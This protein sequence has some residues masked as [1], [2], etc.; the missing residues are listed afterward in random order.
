MERG[1]S[2]ASP[3]TERAS[4]EQGL[5]RMRALLSCVLLT[6]VL[7][8][9]SYSWVRYERDRAERPTVAIV[10]LENDSAE[11]GVETIFS[12]ALRREVLRRGG[13]RLVSDP[14]RADWVIRGSVRLAA[15]HATSLSTV[16]LALERR[17]V[18]QLDL[19]AE[20]ASGDAIEIPHTALSESERIFASADVEVARTQRTEALRRIAGTLAVRVHDSLDHEWA[21]E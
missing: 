21:A 10:T 5:T 20:N 1:L 9:S 15:T 14:S 7:G 17:V 4:L 19:S 13:A 8:C 6:A 3:A 2:I 18:V 11:P 12:D 16:V